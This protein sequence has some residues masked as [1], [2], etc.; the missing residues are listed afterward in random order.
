MK[1]VGRYGSP[2]VRRT[3]ITLNFYG[4]PYEAVAVGADDPA[5]TGANPLGRVPALVLDDGEAIVDSNV[6]LDHLDQ[7]VGPDKALT[8]ASGK[9]RRAVMRATAIAVG[10]AEKAVAAAYEQRNRPKELVHRPWLDKLLGQAVEGLKALDAQLG[11]NDWLCLGR[12]TQA[13][14]SAAVAFQ[15]L[16]WARPKLGL[17]ETC[18]NLARLSEKLAATEPF[19]AAPLP[20]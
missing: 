11:A 12:M 13:D 18:P 8:P 14:I 5:V 1:L 17:A 6:I 10:S 4:L 9:E 15:F 16:A 19:K 2:F 3:A 20:S 7:T